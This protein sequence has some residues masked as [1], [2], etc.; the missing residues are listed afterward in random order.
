M[1]IGPLGPSRPIAST[2]AERYLQRP[3]F[4][5]VGQMQSELAQVSGLMH[6]RSPLT[7]VMVQLHL[8]GS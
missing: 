1:G 8:A 2:E 5:F 3:M 4:V 6:V 7:V